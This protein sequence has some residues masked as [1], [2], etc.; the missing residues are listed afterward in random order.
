VAAAVCSVNV[1]ALHCSMNTL[2]IPPH[3]KYQ[4]VGFLPQ[5]SGRGATHCT[6]GDNTW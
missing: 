1:F 6:Q 3:C 5:T 4:R 2:Y